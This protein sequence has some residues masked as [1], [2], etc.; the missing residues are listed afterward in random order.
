MDSK[1]NYAT[2]GLFVIILGIALVA[3]ILWLSVGIEQKSYQT[4]QVYIQESVSGLNRKAAVK[5]RGVV[6]GYVRDIAL[7][8][9]RPH[10]V[11][12]LLDVEQGVLIKQDTL[13]I[14]SVQGLTGL[15]HIE[16]TGGSREASPP[17]R[18]KGQQYPEIKTKP[19][20]LV[21]LDQAV[22]VLLENLG[23]VSGTANTILKNLDPDIANNF[24]AN[25]SNLSRAV[26]ALLSEKNHEA[27]TNILHNIEIV[28][29]TLVA[30]TDHID[31]ALSNVLETTENLNT[32]SVQVITLVKQLKNSLAAIEN[33][34]KNFS[35]IA[36][37]I[38]NT[39]NAF[40]KSTD[41]VNNVVSS[42]D[43]TTKMIGK[44][45][46]DISVA[47]K[48]SRQD[49][50]YFT[51]QALP[52]VTNSLRELEVLLTNLRHFAQELERKPNMLFFGK[53]KDPPGPGE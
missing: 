46:S 53:E 20:F 2:I 1:V 24:L 52:E 12:V 11:R 27:V 9:D 49:M 6:V 7:V 5:Y 36:K 32:I 51:R 42:I 35:Q 41:M 14:L 43:D 39:S 50:N 3:S 23:N 17:I 22:S 25:I 15:A 45:A 30:R 8:S 13:A 38:E 10:E 47:V 21:K 37:A 18:E 48:E 31:L 34:S 40:T 26:N 33:S 44:T 4:Y 19:S 29:A 28:S 16:L